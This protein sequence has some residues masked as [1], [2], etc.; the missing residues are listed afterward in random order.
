MQGINFVHFADSSA[1]KQD[2]LSAVRSSLSR[3]MEP[4]LDAAA[5]EHQE[6]SA[7]A[8]I[9]AAASARPATDLLLQLF[10]VSSSS[11]RDHPFPNPWQV[12]VAVPP[13]LVPLLRQG[14]CQH[15]AASAAITLVSAAGGGASLA[16]E[17]ARGA[18]AAPTMAHTLQIALAL[19]LAGCPSCLEYVQLWDKC[20]WR[21]HAHVSWDK[22]EQQRLQ[23]VRALLEAAQALTAHQD[24]ADGTPVSAGVAEG[25]L[26]LAGTLAAVAWMVGRGRRGE[27]WPGLEAEALGE[28]R[29]CLQRDSTSLLRLA[30][31][32]HTAAAWEL[33]ECSAAALGAVLSGAQAAQSL[34]AVPGQQ[35]GRRGKGARGRRGN[36]A[37][38][39]TVRINSYSA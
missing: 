4:L 31:D 15:L 23:Y 5:A 6:A 19:L 1:S 7:A 11:R 29:R 36:G 18:T 22:H 17:L 2:K 26:L 34:A 30:L 25:R 39:L 9:P 13:S 24:P 8:E 21:Q 14:Y 27:R 32:Q 28:L 10:S 20:R 16:A 37:R 38:R 12:G 35:R 33:P 3:F